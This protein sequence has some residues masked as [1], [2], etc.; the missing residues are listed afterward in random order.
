MLSVGLK[1]MADEKN[2]TLKSLEKHTKLKIKEQQLKISLLQE[3]ISLLEKEL[4]TIK[5][6]LRRV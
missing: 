6:S 3:K 4:D 1:Q 2:L 5:K